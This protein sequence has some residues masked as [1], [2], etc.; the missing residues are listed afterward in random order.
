MNLI[1]NFILKV[2]QKKNE[3]EKFKTYLVNGNLMSK[4]QQELIKSCKRVLMDHGVPLHKIKF[5][6]EPSFMYDLDRNIIN[7]TY[8]Q[9]VPNSKKM[10]TIEVGKSYNTMMIFVGEY[11][12]WDNFTALKEILKKSKRGVVV[13]ANDIDYNEMIGVANLDDAINYYHTQ[14]EGEDL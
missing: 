7:P 9:L 4:K 3:Q 13:W 5:V 6:L 14:Y 12:T 11:R 8:K 10:P 1:P 2:F